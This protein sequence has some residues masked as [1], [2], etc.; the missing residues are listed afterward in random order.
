[1]VKGKKYR[2]TFDAY[3]EQERTMKV[4]VT[5]PNQ[6]W[7]RYLNDTSLD[8]KTTKQ[9]Y[10]YEFEMKDRTDPTGRLEFNM[11]KCGSTATIHISNVRLEEIK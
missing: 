8:L 4:A 9:S 7:I 1:M 11:G 2:V 5:A 3:A 6:G 10:K